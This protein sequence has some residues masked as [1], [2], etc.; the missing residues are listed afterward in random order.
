MH[1]ATDTLIRYNPEWDGPLR[2]DKSPS[3]RFDN[4]KVKSVVGAF[5]CPIDPWQG[6]RMVAEA[7]P[8]KPDFDAELDALYDRIIADQERLGR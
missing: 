8:P 5:D 7:F 2:G 4:T 3:V 1:V 6:M